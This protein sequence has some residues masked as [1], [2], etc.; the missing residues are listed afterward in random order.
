MPGMPVLLTDTTDEGVRTITLHRPESRNAL[1]SQ[2]IAELGDAITAADRDGDVTVIVLTGTD[3]AFC[4]GLDLKELGSSS[5][6]VAAAVATSPL[7]PT[8]KLLIGAVNGVAVTGGLELALNCDIL[9]ASDRARFADTHARVGIMPGWGLS[10]LLPRRIGLG[11]AIEMSMTG[12][13]V[14]AEQ[15]LAWGLVEHVVPHDSLPAFVASLAADAAGN[16]LVAA[17]HLLAQYRRLAQVDGVAAG[18]A[19][20]HE[21]AQAWQAGTFDPAEV[22][23]RRQAITD[24]GRSQEG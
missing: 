21:A 24:R 1:S 9:V 23:R 4:A 19:V 13:F 10:V 17:R 8:G 7:P 2:L 22:A 14:S 11:R 15:A 18:L 6:L 3:P 20:E 5:G 12:N 16:D